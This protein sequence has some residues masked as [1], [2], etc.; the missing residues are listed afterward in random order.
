M[1]NWKRRLLAGALALVVTAG[2]LPTAALAAGQDP[3]EYISYHWDEGNNKLEPDTN[4]PIAN[5]TPITTGNTQAVTWTAGWYVVSGGTADS[6]ITFSERV[7]VTGE[8]HLI[9]T[10]NCALTASKGIT[11]SEGNSLTIYATSEGESMGKLTATGEN[12]TAG[13]GGFTTYSEYVADATYATGG[14]ITIHGGDVTAT[15]GAGG[16]GI[17]GGYGGQGGATTI[18]GGKMTA[19]GTY[20]AGIGGGMAYSDDY[21]HVGD[22]GTIIIYGGYITAT[23]KSGGAGIGGGTWDNNSSLGGSG[24]TISIYG[25][26]VKATGEGH[27]TSASGAG[28]GGGFKGDGGKIN[29]SGGDIEAKG[30]DSAGIGGGSVGNGG[31]ITISGGKIEATSTSGAGIGGGDQT[32][33][34]NGGTG[35]KITITGGNITAKSENGAGI[36][37]GKRDLTSSGASG[38]A[39]GGTISISGKDTQVKATGGTGACDIG[40][41]DKDVPSDKIEI[42]DGADVT[43]DKADGI[44]KSHVADKTWETTDDQ[45]WHPCQVDGCKEESHKSG[46]GN[47]SYPDTGEVNT[48]GELVF[49]C[50]ATCGYKKT[51]TCTNIEVTT[52][53]TLAYNAG[54]KLDLSALKISATFTKDGDTQAK[55]LNYDSEGV[56]C[57]IGNTEVTN[58]TTLY[59]YSHNDQTITVSIGQAQKDVGT[60][61]VKST[62]TGVTSVTVGGKTGTISGTNI[63]VTLDKG[64]TI[65]TDPGAV[66]ITPADGA[67]VS[68]LATSDGGKTWTF[69]VT[70]ESGTAQQYTINVSVTPPTDAECVTAAKTAIEAKTWTVAQGTANTSEAVKGWI[71]N[72][73]T[74]MQ[75][76]EVGTTVNVSACT[77]ASGS[78]NGS[79]TFTVSLSK[80]SE[81]GTTGTVTGTITAIVTYPVTVTNGT[82]GGSFAQGVTVSISADAPAAGQRFSHWTVE[83]GGMALASASSSATSFIMPAGAVT[84]TAHYAAITYP[85]SGGDDSE[86]TYRPDIED[87][88]GGTTTVSPRNPEKGDK[89]TIT[90]Q[91]DDGYEVENVAVTDRRGRAVEVQENSDGTW[92]FTQPS[93]KVTIEVTYKPVETAWV[94]PFT[95]VAQDDWCY[96]AVEYVQKNGLMQGTGSATFSPD[97]ATSRGMIVA[98]L[99]RMAGSP[100]MEDEIWGYPFADVDSA[101]YYG[102]AVYWARLNGI[103]NGYGGEAFGPNDPISREQLAVMLYNY[104]GQPPVPNL[105]LTFDDADQV[106]GFADSAMRWAV[107][108]GILSGKGNNIL[109]PK[110]QATRAQAAAML[111]RFCER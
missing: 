74:G 14:A 75:L 43:T 89:V 25:G 79:F 22:G 53:P 8:V 91:P 13:I 44:G 80:N 95:D 76:Y 101:A 46:V 97:A 56:K 85:D 10:D 45:H 107:D 94:N 100:A 30:Y 87:S 33:Q 37:G 62:N 58:D 60:L 110:G 92:S 67:T 59:K 34:G 17:G 88:R 18:F 3:V 108:M 93:G 104:A 39:S 49:A 63:T 69:T 72:Q 106:S 103:A 99:W 11:V 16:A 47:H 38:G 105:A 81:T 64:A 7:T 20:G 83:Q 90:P 68:N 77:P 4:T 42:L 52:Q 41:G 86:P 15:G 32:Y 24:G 66:T 65:P 82:G 71:E 27:Y 40:S 61:T 19:T 31:E 2:L 57:Y 109:A 48:N 96:E 29:I 21:N 9:L 84:V 78:A 50:E 51:Y 12:F 5:Y 28:I 73:L 54:E 6:P 98:I 1:R 26:T 35:G 111:M 23:G 70:A 102:T 55:T 36:G